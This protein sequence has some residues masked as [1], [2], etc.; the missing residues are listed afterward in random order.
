MPT[1]SA[2]KLMDCR[3]VDTNAPASQLR[4]LSN[5]RH[6]NCI[7]CF[8]LTFF[9]FCVLFFDNKAMQPIA[10]NFTY[11]KAGA[12]FSYCIFIFSGSKAKQHKAHPRRVPSPGPAPAPACARAQPLCLFVSK[13]QHLFINGNVVAQKGISLFQIT[14][15]H[16]HTLIPSAQSK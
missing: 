6:S 16:I 3:G 10:E 11:K 13:L 8:F 14:H 12:T 9:C 2:D 15:T 1:R 4:M 7:G 5:T